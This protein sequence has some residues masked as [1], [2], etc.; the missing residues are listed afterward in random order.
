[1]TNAGKVI[2]NLLLNSPVAGLVENRIYPVIAPQSAKFPLVVYEIQS[3]EPVNTKDRL[4]NRLGGKGRTLEYVSVNIF[5]SAYE[6]A[7]AENISSEINK[8]LDGYRGNNSGVYVDGIIY[9]D[10]SNDFRMDLE[11]FENTLLYNFRIKY[12]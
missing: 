2:N 11:L 9:E 8:A 7:Q 1:M 3:T 4:D 10:I 5:V 12:L 6:Y